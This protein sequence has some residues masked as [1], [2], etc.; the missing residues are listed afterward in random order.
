MAITKMRFVQE[1]ELGRAAPTRLCGVDGQDCPRRVDAAPE[2][3]SI[4][5][6]Q[7]ANG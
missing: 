4:A 3:R 2:A 5:A 7:L 1:A 6:Q